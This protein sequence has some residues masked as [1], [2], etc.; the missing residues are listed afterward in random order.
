MRKWREDFGD[1]LQN[2]V[3]NTNSMDERKKLVNESREKDR[4][5]YLTG[6]RL[7][8]E[9]QDIIMDQKL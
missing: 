6:L 9:N 1:R 4:M 3:T 8:R 5:R 2:K 7:M